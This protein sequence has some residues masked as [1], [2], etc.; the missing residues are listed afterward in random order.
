MGR[1]NALIVIYNKSLAESQTLNSLCVSEDVC[2]WIADNSTKEYGNKAFAEAHGY[3]YVCMAGNMGLSKAYNRVLSMLEKSDDLVCFFD[4]DTTVDVRYFEALAA[5]AAA[6]PN[7]DLFA[8]VV[9]D[10]KGILSPCTISSVACR[11]VKSAD[12]LPSQGVSVIN[13]GLA[14]RLRVFKNYAYDEGQFL[15]Y[16]DHAF[17]RDIASN[18]LDKIYIMKKVLLQQRFSGSEKQTCSAAIERNRIFTQ[19]FRY[20]CKKYDVSSLSGYLI[21][22]KR[23]L[24]LICCALGGYIRKIR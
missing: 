19:D 12:E 6:H 21:L 17:I 4:D 10:Q 24:K 20:F 9:M 15:D 23:S 8:P 3:R 7:I 1:M 2:V 14:V 13:S 11:R 5:A 16:I 22:L 18:K